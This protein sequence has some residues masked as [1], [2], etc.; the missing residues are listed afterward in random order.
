M[1]TVTPFGIAV[2]RTVVCVHTK[3]QT[4]CLRVFLYRSMCVVT[5]HD[6]I[7]YKLDRLSLEVVP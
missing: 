1:L 7:A 5:T 3:V 2:N 6:T 4:V